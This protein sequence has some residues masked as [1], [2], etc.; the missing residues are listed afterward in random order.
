MKPM[1]DTLPDVPSSQPAAKRAGLP[2]IV[3]ILLL[4]LIAIA[5]TWFGPLGSQHRNLLAAQRHANFIRP[6][7]QS[8]ARFEKVKV[9]AFTGAG[10]SLWIG[11][12]VK[13]EEDGQA[14][15]TAVAST[16][17]PVMTLFRVF[18]FPPIEERPGF[19]K[20]PNLAPGDK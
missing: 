19:I 17:P 8:D 16:H 11:G 6:Q 18:L 3:V 9:E 10:G 1:T 7:I 15:R 12:S 4:G 13:S 14:L 2:R 20:L 5:V